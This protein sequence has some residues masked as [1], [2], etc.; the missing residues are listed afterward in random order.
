MDTPTD[1]WHLLR[2]T[3]Y[4][5][6]L[7][8]RITRSIQWIYHTIGKP[9]RCVTIME[10]LRGLCVSLTRKLW[11]CS[12]LQEFKLCTYIL[13]L[14]NDS[15][16]NLDMYYFIPFEMIRSIWLIIAMICIFILV[17]V[18]SFCFRWSILLYWSTWLQKSAY[19]KYICLLLMA[20]EHDNNSWYLGN[21]W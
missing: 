21:G 9:N 20:T 10:Y 1:G 15:R 18:S 12:L 17:N 13:W 7:P 16:Q 4:Y 8:P 11:H 19:D 5:R 6:I 14:Q 2:F 3:W